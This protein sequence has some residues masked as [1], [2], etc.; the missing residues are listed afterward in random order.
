MLLRYHIWPFQKNPGAT[1]QLRTSLGFRSHRGLVSPGQGT[2]AEPP[3][4]ALHRNQLGGAAGEA[5]NAPSAAVTTRAPLHPQQL[6]SPPLAPSH[7]PPAGPH[8]P[9]GCPRPHGWEKAWE[10]W[11]F[12]NTVLVGSGIKHTRSLLSSSAT[13]PSYYF[14]NARSPLQTH[15]LMPGRVINYTPA[16]QVQ[17]KRVVS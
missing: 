2:M 12:L 6:Q 15:S 14:T 4:G 8:V 16:C 3:T 5:E 11:R 17:A 7:S 1:N 9:G 13:L 10:G